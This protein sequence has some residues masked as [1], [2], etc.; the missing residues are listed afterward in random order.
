[1]SKNDSGTGSGFF[2]T[3]AGPL[4]LVGI[5]VLAAVGFVFFFYVYPY[6]NLGPEQPIPFSH[7]LH[8]GVKEIQCRFCHPYVDRAARPGLPPVRKCLFCH[9]YIIKEHPQIRKEHAYF[10]S[11]TPTPWQ[12]VYYLPE[13]VFF[14]HQPHMRRD[15]AC[16]EC[17][18]E[19]E[20]MDRLKAAVD[21]TMGFCIACHREYEA[22]VGCWLACHN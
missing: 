18:G 10:D 21:L 4:M 16:A 9:T 1:M 2:E 14:S 22:N 7:R 12:E 5:S 19:V 3:N 8:A 17:H 13:H 6:M 20:S 11:S 15:F